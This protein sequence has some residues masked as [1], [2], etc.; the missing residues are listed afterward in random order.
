MRSTSESIPRRELLRV[1]IVDDYR[2]SADTMAMLVGVWGHDVRLAYDGTVGLN[3]I[4]I[5]ANSA[6]VPVRQFSNRTNATSV[7]AKDI[8][9]PCFSPTGTVIMAGFAVIQEF[10][11]NAD[12]NVS[13][14]SVAVNRLTNTVSAIARESAPGTE[15]NW[16]LYGQA[17]CT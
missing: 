8:S 10:G 14:T 2:A 12:F 1:L 11:T 3:G 15:E 4:G 9:V 17:I 5:C 13:V 6:Q 16:Q 7:N